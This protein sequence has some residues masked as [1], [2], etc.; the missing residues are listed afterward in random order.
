MRYVQYMN[1][2]EERTKYWTLRNTT[3]KWDK[4]RHEQ[5]DLNKLFSIHKIT[6]DFECAATET[7]FFEFVNQYTAFH[8]V[9]SFCKFSK[10]SFDKNFWILYY[11]INLKKAKKMEN[12]RASFLDSTDTEES[13]FWHAGK[14]RHQYILITFGYDIK[15]NDRSISSK[16]FHQQGNLTN[17]PFIWVIA[18]MICLVVKLSSRNAKSVWSF[19]E[20]H[21]SQLV[22][23]T[24]F[25]NIQLVKNL[26][27]FYRWH[28]VISNHLIH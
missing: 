27:N 24:W 2:E 9:K 3:C 23:S 13:E 20:S 12:K 19:L 21:R 8:F 7:I 11:F 28:F 14:D 10:D 25:S 16:L 1:Q 4:C 26:C 18:S 15:E 22:W 6:E 17:F 5:N